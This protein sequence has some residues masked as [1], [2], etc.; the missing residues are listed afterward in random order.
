MRRIVAGLFLSLDGVA[1]APNLWQMGLMDEEAGADVGR[2][3]A[4]AAGGLED[5]A[6]RDT[7][8]HYQPRPA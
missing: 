7:I 6:Q 5:H 3:A 2:Q 4:D 8:L 1:E